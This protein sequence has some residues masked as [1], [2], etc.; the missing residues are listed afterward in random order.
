[1]QITRPATGNAFIQQPVQ[2]YYPTIAL[3]Q[4]KMVTMGAWV[5]S[6]L[7][8]SS[9]LRLNDGLA[10]TL[11]ATHP[12]TGWAFL[13]VTATLNA[14]ATQAQVRVQVAPTGTLAGDP[15][16]YVDCIVLVD[17][18]SVSNWF[19]GE[20]SQSAS[21]LAASHLLGR[22]SAGGTGPI[23]PLTLSADSGIAF[24]GTTIGLRQPHLQVN[25]TYGSTIQ[26]P[27]TGAGDWF[28]INITNTA[29]HNLPAPVGA[30]AG[31]VMTLMLFA[32]V[33]SIATCTFATEY[34]Q[35]GYTPATINRYMSAIF[36]SDG[37]Y[38]YQQTP[39]T[40]FLA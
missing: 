39:W 2:N 7:A 36:R 21:Y 20:P 40:S 30:F 14:A 34:R 27:N 11:S 19:P 38:W 15:L 13:T 18:P 29:A 31:A 26:A 22:G 5:Y 1:M 4:G 28:V 37:T 25:L 6:T 24:S 9:W 16:V 8:G 33:S 35:T 12:G 17:G 32:T 10:S 3:W 23:E